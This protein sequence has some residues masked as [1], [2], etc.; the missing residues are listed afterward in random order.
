MNKAQEDTFLTPS[1][2]SSISTSSVEKK[3]RL[4]K[5][6]PEKDRDFFLLIPFFF[7]FLDLALTIPISR[8][9]AQDNEMN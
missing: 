7:P 2:S 8:S 9:S 4:G 1:V 6:P 5:L 3:C